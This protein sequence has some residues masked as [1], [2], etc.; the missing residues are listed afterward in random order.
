MYAAL[1]NLLSSRGGKSVIEKVKSRK[2]AVKAAVSSLQKER[3]QLIEQMCTSW[4]NDRNIR[5][6]YFQLS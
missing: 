2:P 6:R 5:Q 1:K 3:L 4:G